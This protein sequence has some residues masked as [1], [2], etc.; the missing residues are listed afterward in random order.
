MYKAIPDMI[1]FS[2]MGLALVL[3][4]T[5][6]LSLPFLMILAVCGLTD[7]LDG[8]AAR[9][10]DACTEHGHTID[11]MADTVLV[12]VL[13]YCIIPAVQWEAWM[14]IWIAA[15][16]ATRLVAFVI[17]SRRYGRPAFV[18]TCLNKLA[19]ASLF[20]APFLIAL[21]G[22]PIAVASVCSIATVSAAEYLYINV[23]REDYDPDLQSAFIGRS[24]LKGLN[25]VYGGLGIP[26]GSQT[27]S[28]SR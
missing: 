5:E 8:L 3:L 18:H 15:I 17:G 16:A 7:V 14:I 2:R 13:L 25:A 6:P 24:R 22:A 28:Q 27:P 4:L 23:S 26:I 12:V 9:R 10:L 1:S 19:G 11:S 21:I 20:L